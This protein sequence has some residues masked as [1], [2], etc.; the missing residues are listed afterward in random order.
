MPC[1]GQRAH[2]FR[3]FLL[4]GRGNRR[5][6]QNL[7]P[8]LSL[9]CFIV[10]LL[11]APHPSAHAH[12]APR[13]LLYFHSVIP[14]VCLRHAFRCSALPPLAIFVCPYRRLSPRPQPQQAS[15]AA[16]CS[17]SHVV[18][19][20]GKGAAPLDGPWQFH[21]GDD[22]P[23]PRPPLTTPPGSK[24]TADKPWG[25]QSHP[26]LRR[27]R[28]VSP[29]HRH[30]CQS[31]AHRQILPPDS[32]HRRRL[33]SLLERALDRRK[34]QY[35]A[36]SRLVPL[37]AAADVWARPRRTGVLAVRVW[38]APFAS[39]DPAELGGF[40]AACPSWAPRGHRRLKGRSRFP[41]A[42]QP[43]NSLRPAPPSMVW[44]PCS[45]SWPGCATAGNGSSS[46]WPATRFHP[47]CSVVLTGL[48]L[49]CPLPMPIGS[50]AADRLIQD[51]SLWFVLLWL[52]N[53]AG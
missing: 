6:V 1:A 47:L 44:W 42:A 22:L 11:P 16:C 50:P 30:L 7:L 17:N 4:D 37:P 9:Q 40:E 43:A 29:P 45:A 33:R 31:P 20:L 12:R 26:Q 49:P 41:L 14:G 38:K 52:L 13:N 36:P 5:A 53:L 18:D 48:R 3:H 39:N 27:I 34:W 19:G 51:I 21:L 32:S 2:F 10:S 46:G 15:A 35:A 25:A 28:L 24:I 8:L 23:G